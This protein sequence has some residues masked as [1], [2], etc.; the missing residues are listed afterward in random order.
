MLFKVALVS[1]LLRKQ[2]VITC[3][4]KNHWDPFWID[5]M[6]YTEKL[7]TLDYVESALVAH[8][9]RINASYQ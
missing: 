9:Q 7:Q 1:G 4:S 8:S 3:M 5:F 6:L 2:P